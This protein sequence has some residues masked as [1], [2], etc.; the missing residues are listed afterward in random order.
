M[1]E[2]EAFYFLILTEI[3]VDYGEFINLTYFFKFLFIKLLVF[4]HTISSIILHKW[5]CSYLVTNLLSELSFISS[6]YFILRSVWIIFIQKCSHIPCII[7][8]NS[9]STLNLPTNNCVLS[10]LSWFSCSTKTCMWNFP[11]L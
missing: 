8:F 3:F 5:L 1:I 10:N 4:I 11:K 7:A 9:T 6:S 2:W